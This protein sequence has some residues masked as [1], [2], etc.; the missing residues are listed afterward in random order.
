MLRNRFIVSAT[1]VFVVLTTIS[2]ALA[3]QTFKY[4]VQGRRN[5]FI[6]LVTSDGRLLKLDIVEKSGK[7]S[8]EGIIFDKNGI[9]LAVINGVVV[10]VG[11]LIDGYTVLKVENNK[12]ILIKDGEMRELELKKEGE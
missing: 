7:F 4:D 2:L 3:Q 10:K 12:V 9:S 6:S 5:P 8:L 11:D 1:G